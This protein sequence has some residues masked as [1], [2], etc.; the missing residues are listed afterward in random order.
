MKEKNIL[1]VSDVEV[2]NKQLKHQEEADIINGIRDRLLHMLLIDGIDEALRQCENIIKEVVGDKPVK[3]N[4][5]YSVVRANNDRKIELVRHAHGGGGFSAKRVTGG[6]VV[7]TLKTISV[8][9][10]LSTI[11]GF[12]WYHPSE[13]DPFVH[14]FNQ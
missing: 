13:R 4:I 14:L 1:F 10:E 11:H 7:A 8:K 5:I 9:G 3:R 12:T 6:I 2:V